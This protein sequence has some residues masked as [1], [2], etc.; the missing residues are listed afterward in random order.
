M[1]EIKKILASAIIQG[2]S[3]VHINV[4]MPPILRR[5]TELF[6]MNFPKVTDEDTKEYDAYDGRA[7]AFRGVCGKERPRFFDASRRRPQVSCKFSLPVRYNS[8]I[9][10]SD[11]E[12]GSDSR[13]A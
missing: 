4:G 5:N 6:E 3:D 2:A 12:P 8:N 1:L 10:Q 13:N 11:S 7:G 9:I